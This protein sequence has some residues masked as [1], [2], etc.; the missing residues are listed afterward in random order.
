MKINKEDICYCTPVLGSTIGAYKISCSLTNIIA[1]IAKISFNNVLLIYCSIKKIDSSKFN[2]Q[3]NIDASK[4][5]INEKI[6]VLFL[7]FYSNSSSKRNSTHC[8]Y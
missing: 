8:F 2:Y 4:A 3:K 6:K 1:N 5:E 7:G